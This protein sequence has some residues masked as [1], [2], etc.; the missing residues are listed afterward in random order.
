MEFELHL[1][2]VS[3]KMVP[4]VHSNN[5]PDISKST[6]VI[7]KFEELNCAQLPTGIILY[8][9]FFTINKIFY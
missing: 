3:S 5:G 4:N 1:K 6:Q 9:E 7:N 8:I 2:T